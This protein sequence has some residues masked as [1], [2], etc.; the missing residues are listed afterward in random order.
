MGMPG[1]SSDERAKPVIGLT[2]GQILCF[3]DGIINGFDPDT[4]VTYAIY[5]YDSDVGAAQ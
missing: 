1:N 3:A 4:S 2:I 5:P